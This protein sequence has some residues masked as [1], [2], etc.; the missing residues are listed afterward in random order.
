MAHVRDNG[1]LTVRNTA[2][3][4]PLHRRSHPSYNTPPCEAPKPFSIRPVRR[5]PM[6][7]FVTYNASPSD[8][9]APSGISP[10]PASES[11]ATCRCVHEKHSRSR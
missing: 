11:Q 5:F 2:A 9:K 4:R 10:A 3:P 1:E 6:D 8:A 7:G